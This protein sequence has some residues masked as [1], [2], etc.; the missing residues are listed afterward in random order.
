MWTISVHCQQSGQDQWGVW[1]SSKNGLSVKPIATVFHISMED[2][3]ELQIFLILSQ[4][5]KILVK[6]VSSRQ[7]SAE[8]CSL[9]LKVG[10]CKAMKPSFGFN[11]LTGRCE[12]FFYGGCKG[13]MN[14]FKKLWRVCW[15]LWWIRT[16]RFI[17]P[18]RFFKNCVWWNRSSGT[19]SKGFCSNNW[20][21]GLLLVFMGLQCMEKEARKERYVFYSSIRL[22][23]ALQML[24]VQVLTVLSIM[25]LIRIH[26]D[27]SMT[28]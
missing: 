1:V 22:K 5:V 18:N 21:R 17:S 27:P 3:V 28:V 25:I 7:R 2:V 20:V 11:T 12:T 26:A 10:P 16:R 4:K 9:P 6:K 19:E 15:Y 13:I 8:V 23:M 14:T 24:F